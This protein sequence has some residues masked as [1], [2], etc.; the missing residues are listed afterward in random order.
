MSSAITISYYCTATIFRAGTFE[1]SGVNRPA[2]SYEILFPKIYC[3]PFQVVRQYPCVW[4]AKL[5][6]AT[7]HIF[8]REPGRRNPSSGLFVLSF[9]QASGAQAILLTPD[10]GA[11]PPFSLSARALAGVSPSGAGLVESAL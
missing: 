10:F 1:E 2:G 11:T 8:P 4:F 9:T 7:E 5:E 3:H 6:I